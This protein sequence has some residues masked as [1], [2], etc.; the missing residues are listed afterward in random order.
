MKVP[1]KRLHDVA[2][3]GIELYGKFLDVWPPHS[4]VQRLGK[5]C[6]KRLPCTWHSS[7]IQ[8]TPVRISWLLV[9]IRR[10][11]LHVDLLRCDRRPLISETWR[12]YSSKITRAFSR[13]DIGSQ[14]APVMG[15]PFCNTRCRREAPSPLCWSMPSASYSSFQSTTMSE[16]GPSTRM[17]S[18]VWW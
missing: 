13:L 2:H 5:A 16:D 6:Q 12:K 8:L 17:N 7:T 10:F 4:Y 11:Q 15:K 14:L 1:T 18:A 9:N 3:N